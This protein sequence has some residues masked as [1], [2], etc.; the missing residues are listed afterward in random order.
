MAT[1]ETPARLLT[2]PETA[3]RL[4]LSRQSVYRAIA[5]GRL[6]AVQLGGPGTPL[7][8]DEHE[9]EAWLYGPGASPPFGALEPAERGEPSAIEEESTSPQPAGVPGDGE[10]S[11]RF[12]RAT[13]PLAHRET[14]S[15]PAK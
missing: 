1:T 14:K 5:S 7:R 3:E 8:V 12:S 15:E 9:L 11:R 10:S 13:P 6:P 2:V 4:R